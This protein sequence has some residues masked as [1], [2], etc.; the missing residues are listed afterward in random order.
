VLRLE[1]AGLRAGPQFTLAGTGLVPVLFGKPDVRS[2]RA[3]RT[4]SRSLCP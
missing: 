1:I 2:A 3:C 4:T